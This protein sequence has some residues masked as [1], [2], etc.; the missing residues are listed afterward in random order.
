MTPNPVSVRP[1]DT[2]GDAAAKMASHDIGVLP[3]I[4]DEKGERLVGVLT[5]RDVVIRCTALHHDASK[6]SVADHMTTT[7]LTTVLP[8]TGLTELL[9]RMERAK[10]RRVPVVDTELRLLGIVGQADLAR[11]VGPENPALVEEMLV[12]VSAPTPAPGW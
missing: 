1:T 7:G 2:I 8:D 10:I 4:N 5:D 11:C 3:V 12:R 9:D 6:C